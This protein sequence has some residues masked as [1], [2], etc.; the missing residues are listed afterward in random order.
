[1][2]INIISSVALVWNEDKSNKTGATSGAATAYPFG[3]TTVTQFGFFAQSLVFF[4]VFC[5]SL[6]F[7]LFF[8]FLLAILLSAFFDLHLLIVPF[9]IIKL[10]L[11]LP[12]SILHHE[13]FKI[14]IGDFNNY[15]LM[16]HLI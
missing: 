5:R 8:F 4:V 6:Y 12:N 1:M 2:I 9:G 11:M 7:I 14:L 10:Y 13:S 15:K 16:E 3:S